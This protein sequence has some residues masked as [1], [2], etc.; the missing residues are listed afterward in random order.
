MKVKVI[1]G[2]ANGLMLRMTSLIGQFIQE[3]HYRRELGHLMI[4]HSH[5]VIIY[6]Y[7]CII[8]LKLVLHFTEYN[9]IFLFVAGQ[10]RSKEGK[11][12]Y[13]ESSTPRRHGDEAMLRIKL[14]GRSFCMRFWYHMYGAN[15]GSLT[16]MRIV[17]EE[18]DDH[19]PTR[20]DFK[21]EHRE[22]IK[23]KTSLN[24]W[25]PAEVELAVVRSVRRGTVHWVNIVCFV[26][27][28]NSLI[29]HQV[30]TKIKP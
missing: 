6:L 26:A 4:T 15:T 29:I 13:I 1:Q 22:W 17:K 12:I 18:K 16:I 21:L 19:I 24:E 30:K 25:Q 7:L 20:K 23:S 9:V 8:F 14:E 28:M 27:S 11:Y 5:K 3:E 10:R 2:N